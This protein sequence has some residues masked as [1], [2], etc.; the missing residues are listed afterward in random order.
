[1][2]FPAN[3]TYYTHTCHARNIF[4]RVSKHF[5]TAP[6]KSG[7]HISERCVDGKTSRHFHFAYIVR[8]GC[9]A[10]SS[11]IC[12]CQNPNLCGC[13]TPLTSNLNNMPRERE[14]K[15][16]LFWLDENTSTCSS[17]FQ[18]VNVMYI[19]IGIDSA[20]PDMNGFN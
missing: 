15:I 3:S 7:R 18:K 11:F 9:W 13:N 6:E 10:K 16:Y 2:F 17:K 5:M 14:G 12:H 19:G 1:V 8:C 20:I 4:L